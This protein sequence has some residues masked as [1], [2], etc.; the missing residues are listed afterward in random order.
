MTVNVKKLVKMAEDITA[1]MSYTDDPEVVADKV[2]D[3]LNRFWDPRMKQAIVDYANNS[4]AGLP[5]SLKLAIS[6][7]I[8]IP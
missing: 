5:E 8:L 7:L 6:R 1:N 4:G 2:A 3:H